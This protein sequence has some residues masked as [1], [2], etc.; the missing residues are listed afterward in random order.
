MG[1]ENIDY[2]PCRE[3]ERPPPPTKKEM[4]DGLRKC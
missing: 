3:K 4:T 1:L 2:I